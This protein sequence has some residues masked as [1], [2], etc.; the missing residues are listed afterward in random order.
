MSRYTEHEIRNLFATFPNEF[1]NH[2]QLKAK[3]FSRQEEPQAGRHAKVLFRVALI[4]AIFMVFAVTT[5][6]TLV[7]ALQSL[8]FGN[9]TAEQLASFEEPSTAISFRIVNRSDRVTAAPESSAFQSFETIVEL[10][11]AAPF[12]VK[13]PTHLP[14][15]TAPDLL[16]IQK[17]PGGEYGHDVRIHYKALSDG[18][19]YSIGLFQYYAGSEASLD[20]QTT[21]PIQ[22][23]NIGEIEGLVVSD[24]EGTVHI[25]WIKDEVLF[26]LFSGYLEVDTLL[27]IAESV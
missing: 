15:N 11:A 2:D 3:L 19:E 10:Q 12:P 17:L 6:G 5:G 26:E 7:A 13:L 22:K 20:L 14:D 16:S 24:P 1:I 8:L 4:A 27:T 9:S 18:N 23:N 21:Y 25:Y